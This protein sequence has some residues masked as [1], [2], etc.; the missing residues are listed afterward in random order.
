M[1]EMDDWGRFASLGEEVPAEGVR[2]LVRT[3]REVWSWAYG[4]TDPST[5]YNDEGEALFTTIQE[6]DL[7]LFEID[8]EDARS[9]W[10]P[11]RVAASWGGAVDRG[12][13]I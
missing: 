4:S 8:I 9:S 13:E 5:A 1:A 11:F 7:C 3:G 2:G 12:P 10:G 6:D